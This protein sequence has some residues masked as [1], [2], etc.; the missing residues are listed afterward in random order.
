MIISK[1]GSAS[2]LLTCIYNDCPETTFFSNLVDNPCYYCKS[3]NNI[4]GLQSEI[5]Q[6]FNHYRDS[7]LIDLHSP[8][9]HVKQDT[10]H[11][12]MTLVEYDICP[13]ES[14]LF[15]YFFDSE[16]CNRGLGED[17]FLEY[18]RFSKASVST[19]DNS[20]NSYTSIM[21]SIRNFDSQNIL[22]SS[23]QRT[24]TQNIDF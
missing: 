8:D 1:K 20:T 23:E 11:H 5:Y 2:F 21:F 9:E 14:N 13:T 4:D 17:K 10:A 22:K 3:Q 18:R 12:L 16:S 6:E 7:F 24:R 19:S 15:S